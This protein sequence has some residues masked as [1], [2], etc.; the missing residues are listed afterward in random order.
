MKEVAVN[1]HSV[2]GCLS[3]IL[4]GSSTSSSTSPKSKGRAR[5]TCRDPDESPADIGDD[6][7]SEDGSS[8]DSEKEGFGCAI[9]SSVSRASEKGQLDEDGEV[10][11]DRSYYG[12][13]YAWRGDERYFS[14]ALHQISELSLQSHHP[15]EGAGILQACSSSYY[16]PAYRWDCEPY[17][18]EI[19]GWQGHRCMDP[20]WGNYSVPQTWSEA[21]KKTIQPPLIRCDV[22]GNPVPVD[23]L[24]NAQCVITPIWG[25]TYCSKH[26]LDG[27]PFCYT[28]GRLEPHGEKYS[29]LRDGRSICW[30]CKNSAIT[31]ISECQHLIEEMRGFYERLDMKLYEQFPIELVG[32]EE[33]NRDESGKSNTVGLTCHQELPLWATISIPV[34]GPGNELIKITTE[35]HKLVSYREVVKVQVLSHTPRLFTGVN[36]AHE[37][38][39]AW[40]HLDG[41]YLWIRG[42]VN[43][44]G[45]LG[46]ESDKVHEGLCVVVAH[47]WLESE[48]DAMSRNEQSSPLELDFERKLRRYL[49]WRIEKN[50]HPIYGGGFRMV[51]PAV[52]KYGLKG[53][54]DY[55]RMTGG[56]PAV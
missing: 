2:M 42:Q 47:M 22:C 41:S 20:F 44:L 12:V 43:E 9:T 4:R 13:P 17:T 36:L 1:S 7:D 28:C 46:S 27:T 55:M 26:R 25:Q 37:M 18:E 35:P 50:P 23:S 10:N 14:T 39:H 51:Q 33:M 56:F 11:K 34:F 30:D 54:L 21:H 19:D 53:T 15:N 32:L 6:H 45:Y 16:R 38:L 49:M 31:N 3:Q 52:I 8:E 29:L 5:C 48:I 24:G 40:I